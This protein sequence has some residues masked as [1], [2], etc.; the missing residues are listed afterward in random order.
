MGLQ[1]SKGYLCWVLFRSHCSFSQMLEKG[2]YFT[3]VDMFLFLRRG[4]FSLLNEKTRKGI[5][6]GGLHFYKSLSDSSRYIYLGHTFEA[7]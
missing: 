1:I 4:H 5:P 3:A 7:S 6:S 2:L